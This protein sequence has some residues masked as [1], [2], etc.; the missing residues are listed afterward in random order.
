MLEIEFIDPLLKC[1]QS[2]IAVERV[3]KL[4]LVTFK[5]LI[6]FKTCDMQQNLTFT[7]LRRVL[8]SRRVFKPPNST[9]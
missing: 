5:T 4:G 7:P 1:R 2:F 8:K 6:K 9:L 3:A